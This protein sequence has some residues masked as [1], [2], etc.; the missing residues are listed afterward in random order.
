METEVVGVHEIS[1]RW[2]RWSLGGEVNARDPFFQFLA[3]WVAFNGLYS[4][5]YGASRRDR[6]WDRLH[7]IRSRN[8]STGG[9]KPGDKEKVRLFATEKKA[10]ELHLLLL[11]TDGDY[12]EAVSYLMARPPE[13]PEN[14]EKSPRIDDA[15]EF[16][17]VLLCVYQVR[18]NLF[19]GGKMLDS[20]RDRRIVRRSFTIISKILSPYLAGEHTSW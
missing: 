2:F 14:P 9:G 12:K 17:Q 20:S 19:H 13:N 6:W 5:A 15:G 7:D 1:Q 3:V 10:R 11:K 4:W 16:E 8:G 18:N